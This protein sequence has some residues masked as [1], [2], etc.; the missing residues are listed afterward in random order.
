ML[1]LLQVEPFIFE[2]MFLEKNYHKWRDV[3]EPGGGGGGKLT[4][5]SSEAPGS[6][7]L[8]SEKFWIDKHNIIY[9]IH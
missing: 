1:R 3:E 9:I 8:R 7:A 4:R 6:Y 2:N 5:T